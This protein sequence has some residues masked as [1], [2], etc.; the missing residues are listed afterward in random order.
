MIERTFR[1][2]YPQDF[3]SSNFNI[4]EYI[5]V[6]SKEQLEVKYSVY[7]DD[8]GQNI[9]TKQNMPWLDIGD[10]PDSYSNSKQ[11]AFQV[12]LVPSMKP[13]KSMIIPWDTW[14]GQYD[15][16]K[17]RMKYSEFPFAEKNI[18]PEEIEETIT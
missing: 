7:L 4:D 6:I 10:L 13:D 2:Y 8:K 14:N 18:S 12:Y 11:E 9:L 16:L 15:I 3:N 17:A 1:E 5:D